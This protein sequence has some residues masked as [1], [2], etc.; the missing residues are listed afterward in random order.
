MLQAGQ[1][2]ILN[3]TGMN[4]ADATWPL[5]INWLFTAFDPQNAQKLYTIHDPEVTEMEVDGNIT[6]RSILTINN[7][8]PTSGGVYGCLVSNRDMVQPNIVNATVNVLCKYCT[9]NAS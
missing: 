6:V 8:P 5:R 7:V 9:S 4:N 1:T 2:L 3:C